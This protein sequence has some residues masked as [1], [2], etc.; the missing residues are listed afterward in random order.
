MKMATMQL[1]K[2]R[3]CRY[4]LKVLHLFKRSIFNFNFDLQVE[5]HMAPS[6]LQLKMKIDSDGKFKT[7]FQRCV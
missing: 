3:L 1:L 6:S 4:K 2:F 5:V 7:R